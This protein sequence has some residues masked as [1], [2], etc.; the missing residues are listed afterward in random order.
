MGKTRKT[1][2]NKKERG[3][4]L[5]EGR[6]QFKAW[7]GFDLLIIIFNVDTHLE[8]PAREFAV[9]HLRDS[10]RAPQAGQPHPLCRGRA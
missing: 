3:I 9:E 2:I 1:A 6:V 4:F 8:P 5:F 10:E 7:N